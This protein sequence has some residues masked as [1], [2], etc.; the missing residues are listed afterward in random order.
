[1]RGDFTAQIGQNARLAAL[2]FDMHSAG[3]GFELGEELFNWGQERNEA[4]G[5]RNEAPATRVEALVPR[6]E[7]QEQEGVEAK[8]L[9]SA[10]G[11]VWRTGEAGG[12]VVVVQAEGV[13]EGAALALLE[14]MLAAVGFD[15][16]VRGWVGVSGKVELTALVAEIEAMQPVRTLLLGQGVLSILAGRNLG[17]EGWQAGGGVLSGCV[18]VGVTYP[19]ELLL[20]QPLFKRLAWQHLLAW[21][22]TGESA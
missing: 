21:K 11:R 4:R 1:M 7:K 10:A 14:R 20:M 15:G 2:V 6:V 8:V 3:V 22:K 13:L 16:M 9:A 12:L 19:P 18:G 5:T 17:V